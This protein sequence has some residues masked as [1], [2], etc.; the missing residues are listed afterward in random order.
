MLEEEQE[1][2]RAMEAQEFIQK[3]IEEDRVVQAEI[4]QYQKRKDQEQAKVVTEEDD[5][6]M[7][8][9]FLE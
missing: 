9:D 2:K 6:E 1:K 5:A 7:V 8:Q 3:S 4:E